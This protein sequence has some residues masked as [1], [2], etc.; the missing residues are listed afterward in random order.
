MSNN[1][2]ELSQKQW[3]FL[4]YL[5]EINRFIT[6]EEL[7][8]STIGYDFD[9]IRS[10]NSMGYIRW[11]TAG[12]NEVKI[13]ESGKAAYENHLQKLEDEAYLKK[14]N[15]AILQEPIIANKKARNANIIAIVAGALAF[16]SLAFDLIQFLFS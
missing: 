2:I 15:E 6:A 4:Q 7:K 10:I 3:N 11:E 9:L 8:K 16:L 5:Y 1:K 12:K 14:Y 13:S